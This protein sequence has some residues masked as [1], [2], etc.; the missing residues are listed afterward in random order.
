MVRNIL[1]VLLILL[2][3]QGW[4]QLNY[5]TTTIR[6]VVSDSTTREKLIGV[7]VYVKGTSFGA[8]TDI[9]GIF[10]LVVREALKSDTLMVTNIG[11]E[12]RAMTF[13]R[14]KVNNLRFSIQ[15]T[16]YNM[17]SVVVTAQRSRYKRKDNPAIS[18]V[19]KIIARN[20]LSDPTLIYDHFDYER[21]EKVTAS[22]HDFIK[23]P[24]AK[25]LAFLSE[26]RDTNSITGK[27]SLPISIHERMIKTRI[28][29]KQKQENVI[30]KRNEGV[31]DKLSQENVETY[32]KIVL[33]EIDIFKPSVHFLMRD[34]VSPLAASAPSVYKYYLSQDTIIYD[35]TKCVEL[36]FTPFD[37]ASLGFSGK[38]FVTADTTLFI[39]GA[40]LNFPSDMNINFV[41]NMNI[42]Q[43]YAQGDK[44]ER[45]LTK[46]DTYF[47]FRLISAKDKV[48][49]DIR[50]VNSY[51]DFVFNAPD[52]AVIDSLKVQPDANFW[53][54]GRHIP[55]T[56][57][58]QKI[59]SISAELRK[60]P[61]YRFSEWLL[62]LL[63]EEYIHLGPKG[64]FDI[65]SVMYFISSNALEGTRLLFGGVT[66]PY[67][68]KNLFL[69]GYAAYGFHDKR[70]KWNS[71]IEYSFV[72]KESHIRDFP[73]HSL[74]AEFNYDVHKFGREVGELSRDNIF[75]WIKRQPDSALVYMRNYQLIYTRETAMNLN[76]YATA[77]HYTQYSSDV[78]S[79]TPDN[80]LSQFSMSELSLRLRYA[81]GEKLF[82]NARRRK[83]LDMTNP[84]FE[85][86]HTSGFKG[87]L[88]GNYS[89][90]R[91]EFAFMKRFNLSVLGYMMADVRA[92]A[93]WNEVPYMLLPHA[94]VNLTYVL[95][96]N[97]FSLMSPLEFMYDRYAQW[98][99]TWYMNGFILNKIP[100]IKYLKFREVFS[101]KGVYG[102]LTDKN[103][104]VINTR[105]LPFPK[106]S[107]VM[108]REPYMEISIGC[109]N[110][111]KFFR[112]E[113]VRRI[114]YLGKSG[115][116][117]WGIMFYA[118]AKF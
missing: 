56:V 105:N 78:M 38:F 35:D 31:D 57:Q 80:S 53:Q 59:D 84:V 55:I 42:N 115:T 51:R 68:S 64:K 107:S 58:E 72:K 45:L 75:S 79:F 34:F 32:M 36:S 114:T 11:Y 106:Y 83:A 6:G 91:S 13:N 65:G 90:N 82:A 15:P 95:R 92:G 30:A 18:L 85:L 77:R 86:S 44:G 5:P 46:D 9:N 113:Y 70:W 93:E 41:Y 102:S 100:L 20:H 76:F 111:L 33:D 112:V 14:G 27:P 109:E 2:S 1:I 22:L 96:P 12:G 103:N 54:A 4:S 40:E 19:E 39:R 23:D 60:V 24:K 8:V 104:P 117:D 28:E 89:R 110:I 94:N 61:L 3:Q 16:S 25:N 99:I 98:D 118:S 47:E 97:S 43:S 48:A 69:E 116:N 87:V 108:N 52:P 74:R 66:T 88:G 49:F 73:V 21:Y 71:A 62:K 26:H 81:P 67:F 29:G 37:R 101:I 10:T 7:T 63:S 50:R 17:E